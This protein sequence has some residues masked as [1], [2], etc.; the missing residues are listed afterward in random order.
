M[1]ADEIPAASPQ[2]VV[3]NK[4]F[5]KKCVKPKASADDGQDDEE[6]AAAA[7]QAEPCADEAEAE[8]SEQAEAESEPAGSQVEVE[9]QDEVSSDT[10]SES[11]AKDENITETELEPEQNEPM[12]VE[13][14]DTQPSPESPMEQL[15][16]DS[17][18]DRVRRLQRMNC[19]DFSKELSDG[20]A[21]DDEPCNSPENEE[22]ENDDGA[23]TASGA[24]AS[25][26]SETLVMS[27]S[28]P[29]LRSEPPKSDEFGR[30]L[31]CGRVPGPEPCIDHCKGFKGVDCRAHAFKRSLD[32][33]CPASPAGTNSAR[34]GDADIELP[35]QSEAEG[36]SGSEGSLARVAESRDL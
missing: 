17:H 18:K 24:G 13:I 29:R 15:G 20:S 16:A 3:K 33:P 25:S 31:Y 27:P 36:E 11:E 12:V 19:K 32:E 14:P 23:S 6:S 7:S 26:G 5:W 4:Q 10:S 8:E 35:S 1:Q 28:G 9:A 34:D 2:Q 30:C 21:A 22:L